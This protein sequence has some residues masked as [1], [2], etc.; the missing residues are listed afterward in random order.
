[1]KK[2]DITYDYAKKQ[3]QNGVELNRFQNNTNFDDFLS[4]DYGKKFVPEYDNLRKKF[5]D[6]ADFKLRDELIAMRSADQMYRT[7]NYQ[8]NIAKQDSIDKLHEKRLIE[9]FDNIG[10]PTDKIVDPTLWNIE[11]M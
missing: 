10:Y 3:I 2:F 8:D 5:I 7:S 6:N 9:I 11:L 1:L 4:S